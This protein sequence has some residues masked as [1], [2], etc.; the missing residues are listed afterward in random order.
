MEYAI[1]TAACARA[2]GMPSR[3]LGLKR[4]DA[5]TAESGAGHV[6]AE[7]W[8]PQFNKWV[9]VDGQFGVIPELRGEPLNAVEFQRALA[10]NTKELTLRSVHERDKYA[11]FDW[12]YPY[13]F[14]FDFNEDQ[15][16][17]GKAFENES[18]RYDPI[19]R[20]I[21]L[22]PQGAANPKVFQKKTPIKSCVYVSKPST[23]YPQRPK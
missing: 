5:E 1:V 15:R 2:Y 10:E 22:V 17:F 11:Y 6:V 21:M 12:I 8:I 3:V 19:G 20:K 4:A 13:L 9:I 14:Y 7:V 18:R 23:F 16:F